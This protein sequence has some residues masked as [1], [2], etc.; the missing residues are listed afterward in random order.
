MDIFPLHMNTT[1]TLHVY[2]I[3]YIASVN[4]SELTLRAC[5]GGLQSLAVVSPL[6][7]LFV[8]KILSSIQRAT[9]VKTFVEFSLKPL[10]CRD[11]TLP[12]LKANMYSQP[13]E[14]THAYL[15]THTW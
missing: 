12:P 3:H 15:T 9:E 11:P 5:A 4:L 8:L 6:E 13:A 10:R 14:S 2:D 1:Y 7:G